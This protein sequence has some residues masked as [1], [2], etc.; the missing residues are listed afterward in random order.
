MD[1]LENP[2]L[3]PHTHCL[4]AVC[5]GYVR[6]KIKY[7]LLLCLGPNEHS[8]YTEQRMIVLMLHN[9]AISCL[10]PVYVVF[11]KH[12]SHFSSIDVTPSFLRR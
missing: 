4:H 9:L 1:F 3:S 12:F 8:E 5:T 2:H 6:T 11:F 7:T 10:F